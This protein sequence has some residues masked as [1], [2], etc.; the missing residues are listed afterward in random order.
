MDKKNNRIYTITPLAIRLARRL[1]KTSSAAGCWEWGGCRDKNGYGRIGTGTSR[2]T[3]YAHRVALAL[4]LGI[5]EAG[6]GEQ[7]VCHHCDN[8][9]CCNP[10]HLFLGTNADNLGDMAR[11][12]R[13]P[14]TITLGE[15]NGR[16]KLTVA[17]VIA[18][19]SRAATGEPQKS[20]ADEFGVSKTTIQGVVYRKAWSHIPET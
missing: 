13:A 5:D 11:K 19:R 7:L 9:P 14:C 18:I 4:H 20:L 6:L 16:S 1:D 3:R 2:G 15:S 12:G 10:A 8:P 17:A